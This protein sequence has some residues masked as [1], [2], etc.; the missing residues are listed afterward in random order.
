MLVP[1]WIQTVLHSDS[2]PER[3]FE[4]SWDDQQKHKKLLNIQRVTKKKI[5][6]WI[7]LLAMTTVVLVYVAFSEKTRKKYFPV[8]FYIKVLK[9]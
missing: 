2:V 6:F 8:Y 3:F 1:I 4:K 9:L 7:S 5:V